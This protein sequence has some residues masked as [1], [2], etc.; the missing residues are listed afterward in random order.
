MPGVSSKA[1]A[2]ASL[3]LT[4]T[5][6]NAVSRTPMS[7]QVTTAEAKAQTTGATTSYRVPPHQRSCR[8]L[9]FILRLSV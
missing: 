3:S 6:D 9:A 4:S 8:A 7:W 5:R 1:L 2:P